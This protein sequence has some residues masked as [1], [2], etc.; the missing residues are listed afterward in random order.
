MESAG[1]VLTQIYFVWGVCA[2]IFVLIRG[3][4]FARKE[5]Q[6]HELSSFLMVLFIAAVLALL[7]AAVYVWTAIAT[8]I[9]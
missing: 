8:F 5:I 1:Q 7:S 3:F 9:F 2:S 6:K 4:V